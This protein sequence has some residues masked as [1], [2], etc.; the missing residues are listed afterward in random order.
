MNFVNKNTFIP[1]AMI[2]IAAIAV[3]VLVIDN[4]DNQIGYEENLTVTLQEARN[5][6]IPESSK[7][8]IVD[9]SENPTKPE[10][11]KIAQGL[12]DVTSQAYLSNN[13]KFVNENFLE[14]D[15]TNGQSKYV[16]ILDQESEKVLAHPNEDRI[17]QASIILTSPIETK[18]L[19]LEELETKGNAWVHY[20][21]IDPQT[22]QLELKM[23]WL[24]LHNGLIFG[25]GFY[26]PSVFDDER[27]LSEQLIDTVIEGYEEKGVLLSNK[28]VFKVNDESQRYV[29][30]QDFDNFKVIAHP[31]NDLVGMD[32]Y[33]V[34]D[35]RESP[36]NVKSE[37]EEN[38]IAWIHYDFINPDN[39]IAEHKETLLKY[40]KTGVVFGSGYYYTD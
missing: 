20:T 17:G 12:V 29:W 33:D 32:I 16:F 30:A 22:N 7:M 13:L 11:Q 3:I 14:Y 37:L 26:T 4:L 1:V 25:S 24:E 10:N 15:L 18:E 9:A 34:V 35:I 39:S 28:L 6:N 8:V 21:M 36:E 40:H 23:S 19:L 27:K 31:I 2:L 5:G 38:G